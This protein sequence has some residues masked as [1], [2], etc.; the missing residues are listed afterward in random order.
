MLLSKS[1]KSGDPFCPS[2][3]L[4]FPVI[5][6]LPFLCACLEGFRLAGNDVKYAGIL[7]STIGSAIFL[8]LGFYLVLV[9]SN[10][11]GDFGYVQ[12]FMRVIVLTQ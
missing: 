1:L 12:S 7:D 2:S 6:S 8:T 11:Y 3:R 10:M 4:G 5:L 9:A